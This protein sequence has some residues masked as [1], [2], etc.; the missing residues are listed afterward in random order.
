MCSAYLT[1]I[2]GAAASPTASGAGA[3][4]VFRGCG[5][6]KPMAEPPTAT[7]QEWIAA[8]EASVPSP[9]AGMGLMLKPEDE[10]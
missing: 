5:S 7:F 8:I 3:L 6:E 10:Q 2:L 4:A 1:A 9:L